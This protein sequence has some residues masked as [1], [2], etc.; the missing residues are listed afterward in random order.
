MEHLTM[1]TKQE[2]ITRQKKAYTWAIRK[3]K[4]VILDSLELTIHLTRDHITR[5][6][7]G[8]YSYQSKPIVPGR[9]RK[10][11]QICIVAPRI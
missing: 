4:S 6:L 5:V 1:A 2:I 10:F 7:N 8:N 11:I 9:G 3:G